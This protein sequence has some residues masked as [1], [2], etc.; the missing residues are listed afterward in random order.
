MSTTAIPP[1]DCW[2]STMLL[3]DQKVL[4]AFVLKDRHTLNAGRVR[5][6]SQIK[7]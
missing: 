5:L 7:P 4:G 3:N 1:A 6:R 2:M